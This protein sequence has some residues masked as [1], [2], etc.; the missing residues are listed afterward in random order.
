MK[1]D[2]HGAIGNP[3][4]NDLPPE[5]GR[6]GRTNASKTTLAG[7]IE[8]GFYGFRRPQNIATR[9]LHGP[10]G[11]EGASVTNPSG[12]AGSKTAPR[13]SVIPR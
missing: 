11:Q 9:R 10:G 13:R 7:A 2:R 8:N 12:I 5:A 4:S 3:C 6:D 1:R